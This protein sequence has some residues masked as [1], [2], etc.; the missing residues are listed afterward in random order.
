[1]IECRPSTNNISI[2]CERNRWA[3]LRSFGKKKKKK[4][5]THNQPVQSNSIEVHYPITH[6][7]SI[8]DFSSDNKHSVRWVED[9]TADRLPEAAAARAASWGQK[10]HTL[11][12]ASMIN[13]N[14]IQW[15]TEGNESMWELLNAV[16]M[17]RY[18][19]RY[20]SS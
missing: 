6:S 18:C 5:N 8:A 10:L 11:C 16:H 14:A 19:N 4:K 3:R 9:D 12:D 17:H 20:S 2:Q 15:S 7:S 1:M 13:C